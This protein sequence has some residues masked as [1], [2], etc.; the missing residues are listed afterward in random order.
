CCLRSPRMPAGLVRSPPRADRLAG[1][2]RP[3]GYG[4]GAERRGLRAGLQGVSRT[5]L[6]DVSSSGS[7]AGEQAV[8][9]HPVVAGANRV[10]LAASADAERAAVQET[11]VAL[12]EA[13]T[14]GL[15]PGPPAGRPAARR[16]PAAP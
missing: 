12:L 10:R 14:A 2:D 7:P 13:A 4:N 1:P 3:A 15:H 8:T 9:V 11:V 6:I 5:G 16:P